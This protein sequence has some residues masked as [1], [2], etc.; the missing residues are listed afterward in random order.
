MNI[1]FRRFKML[2]LQTMAGDALKVD[3]N[4]GNVNFL[5][6]LYGVL[7]VCEFVRR[8]YALCRTLGL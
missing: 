7:H 4:D 5:E 1:N 8:K 3:V 6:D 2:A